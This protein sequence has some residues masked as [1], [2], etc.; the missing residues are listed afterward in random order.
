[1]DFTSPTA[2]FTARGTWLGFES[3]NASVQGLLAGSVFSRTYGSWRGELAATAGASSYEGLAS[4][5][6][7]LARARV[8]LLRPRGGAWFAATLGQASYDARGHDV[9]SAAAGVWRGARRMNVTLAVSGTR[10]ADTAYADLEA[11]LFWQAGRLAIESSVG[12]RGGHGGGQGVYGEAVATLAFSRSFATTVGMGRYPTDPVRGSVAGRYVSLGVR[13]TGFTPRPSPRVVPIAAPPPVVAAAAGTNGHLHT[14][15]ATIQV[16]SAGAVL[17]I[18]A[19]GAATVEVMGDFT[20]W[21]PVM[22][23]RAGDAWRLPTPLASGPRRLNVRVDG[24]PW[25]VP[26]GATLERDDYGTAVGLLVVP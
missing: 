19:P 14:A 2:S 24:G 18:R 26:A 7:V 17:M 4:F 6:H 13:V 5:A 15:V 25:S 22:L 11:S 16:E 1:M 20:D 23:T 9:V 21:E 10:V 3:G 12:A 8:H